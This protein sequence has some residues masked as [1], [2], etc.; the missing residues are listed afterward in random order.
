MRKNEKVITAFLIFLFFGVIIFGLSGTKYFSGVNSLLER[1]LAP[2]QSTTFNI[3]NS[4]PQF[5]S[6]SK[7]EGLKKENTELL[8]Q[9]VNLKTLEKD[10]AALKDQFEVTNPKSEKLLPAK[11]I[12]APSFIPGVSIPESFTLDKGVSD[13]IKINQAVLSNNNIVGKITRVSN[14]LSLVSL[15]TN[16]SSSFTVKVIKTKDEKSPEVLGVIKGKGNS[17]MLLENVVLSENISA[18]DIIVTY[19]SVK[20]DGSGYPPDLVVGKILKN[21]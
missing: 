3:F 6:D 7:L 9:L 15:L 14:N 17:E 20:E 4:F 8:K 1:I 21:P 10:N 12:G 19:G 5:F 16:P 18:N 13:G 11:I 2:F